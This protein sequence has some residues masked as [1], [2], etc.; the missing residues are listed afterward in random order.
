[1]RVNIPIEDKTKSYL[2]KKKSLLTA[3]FG[4]RVTWDEFFTKHCIIKGVDTK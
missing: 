3:N 2:L 1:M 4:K